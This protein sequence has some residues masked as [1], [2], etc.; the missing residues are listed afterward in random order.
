MPRSTDQLGLDGDAVP[1]EA[2]IDVPITAS[3]EGVEATQPLPAPPADSGASA[4][5]HS[6]GEDREA[7]T[8]TEEELRRWMESEWPADGSESDDEE[9]EEE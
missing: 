4:G 8:V 7:L 3:S 9:Q 1:V 5:T 6:A 2:N